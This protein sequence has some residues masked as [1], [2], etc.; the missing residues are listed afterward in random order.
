MRILHLIDSGGLYGAEVM[1]LHLMTAQIQLGLIPILVS[2]GERDIPEKSIEAEA[3]ERGLTVEPFR[4]RAGFNLAGGLRVLDFARAQQVSV[5]HTHGYKGN[6]LFGAMPLWLRRFPLVATV[7][8]WTWTG[9]ISRMMVYEWLDGLCLRRADAVVVVNEAMTSHSRLRAIRPHCLHTINNGIPQREAPG[10]DSRP[11]LPQ[12]ILDF[13][14]QG[15]SIVALGR[16]SVEKGLDILLKAVAGLVQ[17]GRDVRLVLVGEGPLRGELQQL[18]EQLGID[19]RVLLPGFLADASRLLSYFN[20]FA[21]PSLTEGLPMVV[22]EAMQAGL[23]I[24]ASRVGGIP[25]VLDQGAC[26]LLTPAGDVQAVR[27]ALRDLMENKERA[28]IRVRKAKERV[29]QLYS[30]RAMAEGYL[31]VY[32]RVQGDPGKGCDNDPRIVC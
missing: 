6:I 27:T 21:L 29:R 5:L 31:A 23:P 13:I 12:P 22:L 3:R 1:L 16:L 26:G 30:S 7:H 4:M 9:G 24:V 28:G 2:M 18:A 11:K 8:G 10:L 15:T 14:R 19:Q 20:I 32:Q 17:E 25:Q